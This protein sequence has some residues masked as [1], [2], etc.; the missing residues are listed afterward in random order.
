MAASA[1][2]WPCACGG[3]SGGGGG[4]R[5]GHPRARHVA[6][7]DARAAP[8]TVG[9]AAAFSSP[10]TSGA[11]PPG[12]RA[13]AR[14]RALGPRRMP[15]PEDAAR[16]ARDGELRAARSSVA[17]GGGRPRR[18]VLVCVLAVV[19][20]GRGTVPGR[21]AGGGAGRAQSRAHAALILGDLALLA[22]RVR[23]QLDTTLRTGGWAGNSHAPRRR[24]GDLGDVDALRG[25]DHHDR[26]PAR[27]ALPA[28]A[29]R[30][31][32]VGGRTRGAS[33]RSPPPPLTP[34]PGAPPRSSAARPLARSLA[35]ARTLVVVHGPLMMRSNTQSWPSAVLQSMISK[36]T[37]EARR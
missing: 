36:L 28:R 13:R 2:A 5:G 14:A 17:R 31:A 10:P 18:R 33:R 21:R 29:R 20:G 6:S 19:V 26:Q 32:A 23:P 7:A 8:P 15:V 35:R 34:R 16:T 25:A 27:R 24:R 1:A 3:G 12:A 9:A 37:P 11:R 4:G 30:G 22:P